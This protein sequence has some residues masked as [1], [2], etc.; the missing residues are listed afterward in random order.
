ARAWPYSPASFQPAARV[1]DS[2]GR[3]SSGMKPVRGRNSHS[4]MS[5]ITINLRSVA[6]LM[7][8]SCRFSDMTPDAVAQAAEGVAA[9]QFI[10]ARAGQRDL[11]M[12][13][14]AAGPRRH[15]DHLV[16]EIDRF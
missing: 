2:D 8:A 9:Q 15:H 5:P 12:I 7:S 16:G 14:D 3:N 6:A 13:D 1:E 4:A 10:G 11:Q